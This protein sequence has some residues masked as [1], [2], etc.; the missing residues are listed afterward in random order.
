MKI[1]HSDKDIIVVNKPSG[2]LSVPGKGP[3]NQD[4]VTERVKE[5]FPDCHHYPA[6][7]RLDMDT[8]GVM[9]L[10]RTEE[11]Y[12]HL[13]AQFRERQTRKRYFAVLQ[14]ELKEQGGVVDLPI[15]MDPLNRPYQVYDP[16]DGKKSITHWDLL[17]THGGLSFVEFTPHTG[18]SHQ[19]RVHSSHELGLGAPILGDRLYGNGTGPG[20]LFLHA[21]Y[22]CFFHPQ[23]GEE[24]EFHAE[25]PRRWRHWGLFFEKKFRK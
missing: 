8:S 2:L 12:K 24:V 18:R 25:I 23:T 13:C 7:H 3:E 11:S 17:G 19:L 14:G 5:L 20:Q 15:R 9:V 10:G 1:L 22:L 21:H 6:A 4:C 16:V